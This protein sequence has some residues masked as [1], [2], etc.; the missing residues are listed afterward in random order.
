MFQCAAMGGFHVTQQ[1]AGHPDQ[2]FPRRHAE[3]AKRGDTEN[4]PKS[5]LPGSRGKILGRQR[6]HGRQGQ[7]D[8]PGVLPPVVV[9]GDEDLPRA[10]PR[11]LLRQRPEFAAIHALEYP[12]TDL[13]PRQRRV[14]LVPPDRRQKAVFITLEQFGVGNRPRRVGSDDFAAHQ[15]LGRRRVLDLL[16][17]RNPV[18]GGQEFAEVAVEGVMRHPA[19]RRLDLVVVTAPGQ[20]DA[21]DRGGGLSIFEEQFVEITHPVEQEG[22]ARLFLE[23]E[24]LTKHRREFHRS[25]VPKTGVINHRGLRGGGR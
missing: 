25:S 8:R 13:D 16:G 23:V 18:P 3:S 22:R 1:G 12:C 20:G 4:P 19:H 7:F 14:T 21:E 11:Q 15:T 5:S 6:R 24:I 9:L 17:N 2:P 10:Q